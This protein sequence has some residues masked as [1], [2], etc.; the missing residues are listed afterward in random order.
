MICR[1]SVTTQAWD[2]DLPRCRLIAEGC[3]NAISRAIECGSTHFYR[4]LLAHIIRRMTT[5]RRSGTAG[6]FCRFK[7]I[8]EPIILV[9][10]ILL[11]AALPI[12]LP[13]GHRVRLAAMSG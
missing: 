13:Y 4:Q 8:M 7:I 3:T 5:W 10:L 12:W 9:L 11:A 2:Y 6:H 1:P